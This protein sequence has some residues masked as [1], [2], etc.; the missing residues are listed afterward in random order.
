MKLRIFTE[1]Q[2]G[3]TYDELLAVARIAER[4]G[5]DAFFRSDHYM[6]IGAGDPGPGSTDAW[7]TLAGLARETSTI[8][9]GTLVT[10]ATFRLPGPLAI[11]VAQVDQMSGGR[12]ELGLGTGWFDAEHTAYGIP[13]PPVGERFG[14][15]EEQLEILTGLWTTPEGET[16]SFEGAYYRLADSPALPKPAQRP[17]PPIIIGG[18]GAKRTPRLAAR[19]ADEYNL[20]FR[21]L[22][23]TELA[24]DR[25]RKACEAE[26][27]SQIV[28]SVVQTVAVG[29]DGA[30]IA[31]RAEAAGHDLATLR[32]TGLAGTP[33]EV[34]D[35]IGKFA[36]LGADRIY[37]QVMD[38][39]DLDHLELIAAEV[40]THV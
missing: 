8:R 36:G 29:A 25:V 14:R 7:V 3:A 21:T 18:A 34:V 2:Q 11:S 33:A 17:R 1:P 32:A 28:L 12:V 23:D 15:F 5:F 39:S 13:F 35:K 38:L 16:F 22:D 27:R 26:G 9:L 37:L 40:L 10:P 24:F 19:F 30:E 20:G 4:L 6:R 31:R